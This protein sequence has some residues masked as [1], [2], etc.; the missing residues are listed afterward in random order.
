MNFSLNEDSWSNGQY[1]LWNIDIFQ[2]YLFRYIFPSSYY[3]ITIH[4]QMF[5]KSQWEIHL[6]G[7]FLQAHHLKLPFQIQ[8][9]QQLCFPKNAKY[10]QFRGLKDSSLRNRTLS[11]LEGGRRVFVGVMKYFRQILMG[12]KTFLKSFDRP[13]NVFSCSFLVLTFSKFIWKFK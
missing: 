13:Q 6:C 3:V 7:I 8:K 2:Y 11:M 9:Q 10:K 5:Q 12:H 4:H 1:V